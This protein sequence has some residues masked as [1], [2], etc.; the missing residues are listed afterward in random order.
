MSASTP[1]TVLL[2]HAY[3]LSGAMWAAQEA[4]LTSAGL[5]VTAPHL[6]GFGGRG[7]EIGSLADAA[8]DLLAELP[9]GPLSVVGLSMGGYLALELLT[10][11]PERFERVVLADTTARAD[12]EAK[13]RDRRS[14]AG[15]VRLE[16]RGFLIEAAEKEHPAGTFHQIVPMIEAASL[17]GVAAALEAMAARPKRLD[18]LRAL[19]A[20]LLVLVG[21]DD[22]VTPPALA[23]E[24]AEAGR[25]DLVILPGAQH[26]SNLDQPAAFTRALLDFLA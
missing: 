26:L 21:E 13:R 18:T 11:A 19:Q 6:P 24:M 1:R 20:P 25:G 16:G 22:R 7:G 4:A 2:L 14:Q 23:R 12:D 5:R 10:Q 15:R 9:E 3:P 17:E 8:R